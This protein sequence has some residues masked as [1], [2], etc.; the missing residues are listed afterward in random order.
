MKKGRSTER[1]EQKKRGFR[2]AL[3]VTEVQK[4]NKKRE[5]NTPEQNPSTMVFV[6]FSATEKNSG[7]LTLAQGSVVRFPKVNH[8]HQHCGYT[9]GLFTNVTRSDK[10]GTKSLG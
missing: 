8:F 7:G 2:A 9:F 6:V 1:K 10:S 4:R 5:N 3:H